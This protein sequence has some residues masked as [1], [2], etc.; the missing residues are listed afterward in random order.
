MELHEYTVRIPKRERVSIVPLGDFHIG[1]RSCDKDKLYELI[2]WIK[3]TPNVY[4]IGMGD[5]ADCI[6]LS[7]P[8]FSPDQIDE[9]YLKVRDYL[10]RLAQIQADEVI[11]VFKPIQGRIIGLGVGNHELTI[12]KKYHYDFMYRVC[13]MLDVKYL[14]WTSLTRFKIVRSGKSRVVILFSEHSRVAGRKKGSK[15][16]ALEDRSNDFEADIYLRGHSHEKIC[17]TKT[18]LTI[19]REGLLK[20]ITRKKVYAICP[21]YFLPYME[22]SVSYAEVAGYPPTSTGTVRIDI[23]LKG[24]DSIDYHIWQ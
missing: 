2:G 8:R 11:K 24:D 22:G 6:N 5:Y 21:S 3:R 10:N 13:G 1:S 18:S 9:D 17:T 14:G 7:D 15:I 23:M 16:N 4:V 19:Q 20:L 12:A